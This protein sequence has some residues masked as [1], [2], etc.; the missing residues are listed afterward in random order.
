MANGTNKAK[1]ATKLKEFVNG[2]LNALGYEI[3]RQHGLERAAWLQAMGIETVLDVGAN[4]GQ[5]SASIRQLLPGAQIY[6]FEPVE[7]CFRELSRSNSGD[8]LFQS[9]PYALG[10]EDGV[11]A[12]NVNDFTPSS[13]LLTMANAHVTEFPHT[14]K[15]LETKVEIRRLDSVAPDLDLSGPYMVKVDVQGFELQVIE[16]GR[17]TLKHADV[18]IIEINF[19]QFYEGQPS[20]DDIYRDLRMCGMQFYGVMQQSHSLR[21][22]RPLFCDALFVRTDSL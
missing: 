16:G 9:F 7:D 12:L 11:A 22:D 21:D 10:A 18:V 15:T 1:L 3:K 17:E 13:S 5:F 20:F 4:V 14:E 2:G 8:G 19:A 6:A